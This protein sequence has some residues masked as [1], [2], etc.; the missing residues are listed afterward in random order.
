MCSQSECI[1]EM[2][3]QQVPIP[4][5]FLQTRKR[6][7]GPRSQ[8]KKPKSYAL[9][10]MRF[11]ARLPDSVTPSNQACSGIFSAAYIGALIGI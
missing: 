11:K 2:H 6:G 5:C 9:K 7:V 1:F 8:A 4:D 10:A 3:I